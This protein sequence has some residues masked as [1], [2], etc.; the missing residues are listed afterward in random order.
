MLQQTTV[1]SVIPYFERWMRLFPDVRTLALA[2]LRRVLSG[3]RR[4]RDFPA[5]L[6]H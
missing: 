3:D 1:S 5:R 4:P 2:P 6:E